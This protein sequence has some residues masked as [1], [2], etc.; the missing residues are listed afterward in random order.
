MRL[1]TSHYSLIPSTDQVL[2][3]K[4]QISQVRNYMHHMCIRTYKNFNDYEYSVLYV[5][6]QIG[7][8]S[9]ELSPLSPLLFPIGWDCFQHWIQLELLWKYIKGQV[10]SSLL[11]SLLTEQFSMIL[12]WKLPTKDG[13]FI[14]FQ[15]KFSIW[16]QLILKWWA[17]SLQRVKLYE[18]NS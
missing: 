4:H 2:Q 16:L 17:E 10:R 11:H 9:S 8:D 7:F 18:K 12:T 6:E 15:W 1:T 5:Y 3:H 13:R 14:T